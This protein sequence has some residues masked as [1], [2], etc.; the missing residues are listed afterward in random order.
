MKIISIRGRKQDPYNKQ[1]ATGYPLQHA[2]TGGRADGKA[3]HYPVSAVGTR[4]RFI[5]G[6]AELVIQ[7]SIFMGLLFLFC[8]GAGIVL[9]ALGV[10]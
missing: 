3:G 6:C 4:R 2:A 5:V 8:V 10:R 9:Q 7:C 1:E